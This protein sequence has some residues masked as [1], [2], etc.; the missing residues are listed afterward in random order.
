MRMLF[1]EYLEQHKDK[2]LLDKLKPL[3]PNQSSDLGGSNE[4]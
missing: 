3:K 1:H 2:A 4:T